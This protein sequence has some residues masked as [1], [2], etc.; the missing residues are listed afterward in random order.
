MHDLVQPIPV[1]ASKFALPSLEYSQRQAGQYWPGQSISQPPIISPTT[2]LPTPPSAEN[3]YSRSVKREDPYTMAAVL[4]PQG[5]MSQHPSFGAPPSLTTRR[6]NLPGPLELPPNTISAKFG[7]PLSG[8]SLSNVT[9]THPPQSS[10]SN[11]L[12]P[13]SNIPGE[14]L[15]P[16]SSSA[17]SSSNPA[18][19]GLPPYTPNGYW[20][21]SGSG[22]AQYMG[23]G[24]GST[25]PNQQSQQQQPQTQS[26]GSFSFPPP[27][28]RFSPSLTS[29]MKNSASSGNEGLPPPNYDLGALPPFPNSQPATLP[30]MTTQPNQAMAYNMTSQGSISGISSH[31]SPINPPDNY[32]HR[33]PPTPSYYSGSQPSS[34][35]QHSQFPPFGSTSPPSQSPLAPTTPVSRISPIS[36]PMQQYTRPY[37]PYNMPGPVLSNIHNPNS[38]LSLVG[39]TGMMFNSGHAAQMQHYYNGQQGQQPV[40]RPFKCDQCPQSFNRNHDLKRHKRIHLAVKPFPCG[41]CDKSFSRKDALKVRFLTRAGSEDGS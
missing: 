24:S 1:S 23:N 26:W 37:Q 18:A 10:I 16:I 32:L 19:I 15:S 3:E 12:T 7:A 35:P 31:T 11:L 9:A 25:P 2:T 5:I 27:R 4:P 29:L 40:D 21:A 6:N 13:P 41:H 22:L 36:Q 34:T 28:G 38:H 17:S 20:S 30:A 33:L 8:A 39:P 14:S